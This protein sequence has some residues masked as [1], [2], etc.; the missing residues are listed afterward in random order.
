M[1]QDQKIELIKQKRTLSRLIATQILYQ[2]Y[3]FDE[4]KDLL[5]IKNDLLQNYVLF[6]DDKIENYLA[7]IDNIFVDKLLENAINNK[8]EIDK[9]ILSLKK[10]EQEIEDL[11]FNI[12]R[13]ASTE[14]KFENDTAKEI[15]IN[16]YINI[17]SFF[18]DDSKVGFVNSMIENL[19][20][21]YG[22]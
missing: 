6:E 4:K 8:S 14:L 19:A 5:A 1:Q 9:N 12:L 22:R 15:I 17:T 21:K 7:K 11:I 20:T 3:F 18:C 10:K 16:E 13:L 2:Y